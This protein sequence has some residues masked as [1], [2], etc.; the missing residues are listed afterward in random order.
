MEVRLS[1]QLPVYPSF[2]PGI[3]RA[4]DRGYSLSPAQTGTALFYQIK[5]YSYLP[6]SAAAFL[7]IFFFCNS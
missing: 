6:A 3:R 2:V 1:N 7:L 5:M 4:P